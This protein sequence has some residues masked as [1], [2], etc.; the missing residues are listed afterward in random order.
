MNPTERELR[1]ALHFLAAYGIL[2]AVLCTGAL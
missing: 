2:F 1:G